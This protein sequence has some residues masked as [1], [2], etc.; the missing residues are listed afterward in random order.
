MKKKEQNSILRL[1][2]RANLFVKMSF[3]KDTAD[4]VVS[5][6]KQNHLYFVKNAK[7]FK[8]L[9]KNIY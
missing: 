8:L 2:K 4:L 3:S 1:Q 7:I 5:F 6:F 9:L